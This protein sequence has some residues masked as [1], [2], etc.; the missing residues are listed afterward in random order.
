MGRWMI[1]FEVRIQNSKPG[2]RIVPA[3]P[4]QDVDHTPARTH[5]SAS[6]RVAAHQAHRA[7]S[8]KGIGSD[9]RPVPSPAPPT[10]TPA[11]PFTTHRG[12]GP[13][14]AAARGLVDRLRRG[15]LAKRIE[16]DCK[17]QK[18]KASRK[19][20]YS[21]NLRSSALAEQPV[22]R[23]EL[24]ASFSRFTLLGVAS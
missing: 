22:F 14:L 1:S 16:G 18:K 21:R 19:R 24:A 9:T 2:M 6:R 3:R 10:G 7:R 15:Q 5:A 13:R 17:L 11:A 20:R 8:W 23:V 12:R 4:V